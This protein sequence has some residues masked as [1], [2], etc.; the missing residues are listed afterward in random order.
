M[1]VKDLMLPISECPKVPEDFSLF[2]Q[3]IPPQFL[4][5][6]RILRGKGIFE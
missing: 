4:R 5:R 6:S 3:E 1:K 2:C